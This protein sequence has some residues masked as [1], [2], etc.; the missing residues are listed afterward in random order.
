MTRQQVLGVC[1]FILL[2]V[3]LYQIVVIFRPFLVPVL[4]AAILA[5]LTFSVHRR[6]TR[7]LRGREALSAALLTLALVLLAVFP[8]VYLTL[9]LVQEAG[10]AYAE[11]NAWIQTGGVRRLSEHLSTLPI[12]G[13]QLQEWLGRII[14]SSEDFQNSLLQGSKTLSLFLMGQVTDLA[15][16][17]FQA[18]VNFLVMVFTLFFF[19]KDG[20]RLYQNLYRVIPLLE[21]H[22][23]KVFARLDRTMTAVVHGMIITALVQGLV[24]GI[25]YWFL[26]VPFP[27]LLTALT[28]LLALL[29]FGGTALVWGPVVIYL[30]WIGPIWKAA[31]MLAWGVGVVVMVDNLLKP[32][33]IGHGAQLPALFLFFSI[34]GGLAAYGFI[35]LFLGPIL[36]AILLTVI[37][38]YREEYSDEPPAPL[39]A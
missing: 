18:I 30:F 32:A 37:Q 38:I 20:Y 3:L 39:E 4:W 1:F 34:L 14:V 10:S 35:G 28:A 2:L 5:R 33:L 22:K 16:N 23:R 36:L 27:V 15:R 26:G 19:F 7:W 25:A 8:V 11:I 9:L 12:P 24:A 29:P 17:A 31:V 21:S 6:M 13:G